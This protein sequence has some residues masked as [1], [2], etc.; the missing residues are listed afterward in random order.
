MGLGALALGRAALGAGRPPWGLWIDNA[1]RDVA[2]PEFWRYIRRHL[3]VREG[4]IMVDSSR[5][6]WDLR[7]EPDQLAAACR[8][9]R[10]Q[11]VSVVLTTWPSPSRSGIDEHVEAL[12][13]LLA[14]PGVRGWE[15]DLEGQWTEESLSGFHSYPAASSY[16]VDAM[17]DMKRL[18]G[19]RLELT[20]H[21]GH[22]ECSDTAFVTPFMDR[23]YPQLYSVRR[24]PYLGGELIEWNDPL[25]GPGKLQARGLSLAMRVPGVWAGN[26]RLGVGLALWDQQWPGHTKREALDV[27]YKAALR[28]RPV[29]TR[30]WSS[31]FV[32]GPGLNESFDPEIA[33]W[34]H[35]TTT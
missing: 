7:L 5:L 14:L 22:R 17:Y 16:L 11:G 24:P 28:G 23:F 32:M 33:A 30:G 20:T 25:R 2:T 8:Y 35:H 4:A 1:A 21:T 13:P 29:T 19:I 26:V 10:E 27:A 9:A 31:K 15:V 12:R 3:G 34:L 18:F 6:G